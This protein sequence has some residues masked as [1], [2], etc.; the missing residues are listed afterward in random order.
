MCPSQVHSVPFCEAEVCLVSVWYEVCLC[1]RERGL[2][3][4]QCHDI[5]R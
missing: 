3:S 5:C 2:Q 4:E 1:L